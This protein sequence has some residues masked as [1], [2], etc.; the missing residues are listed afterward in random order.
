MSPWQLQSSQAPLGSVSSSVW[1]VDSPEGSGAEVEA[2]AAAAAAA[3]A[4]AVAVA[5]APAVAASGHW[6]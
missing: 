3:V 6:P 2:E 5:V 4:V 1:V